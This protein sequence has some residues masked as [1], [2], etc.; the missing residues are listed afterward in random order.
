MS[1]SLDNRIVAPSINQVILTHKQKFP[2]E[3]ISK[4]TITFEREED[5]IVMCLSTFVH[6]Y[7][8]DY[9]LGSMHARVI[10]GNITRTE[11]NTPSLFENLGINIGNTIFKIIAY[12]V[13]GHRDIS[14]YDDS[15]FEDEPIRENNPEKDKLM[16]FYNYLDSYEEPIIMTGGERVNIDSDKN[17][18]LLQ[19]LH[20]LEQKLSTKPGEEPN[21]VSTTESVEDKV[22]IANKPEDEL[23]IV[24]TSESLEEISKPQEELNIEPTSESGVPKMDIYPSIELGVGEGINREDIFVKSIVFNDLKDVLYVP[25]IISDLNI[26]QIVSTFENNADFLDFHSALNTYVVTYLGYDVNKYEELENTTGDK[27]EVANKAIKASLKYIIN[28][29]KNTN[30]SMYFNFYGDI[31][32]L[33]L[34]SYEFI[35]NKIN[36]NNQNPFDILNSSEILYQFIIFYI[37]YISVENYDT[38]KDLINQM[39]GGDG[40]DDEGEEL[41]MDED[42]ASNLES[43]TVSGLLPEQKKVTEEIPEYVFITHNNLLTTITRGM[44]IKLGIWKR[45]F[46]PDIP[47]NEITPEDYKFGP[48][49]LNQISY[50]KLVELF[51]I[52]KKDAISSDISE[53]LNKG[54]PNNELLIL[55]ILILKRL[56]VEMSPKKTLTFGAKIDDD[57]KNYMDSFYVYN[58]NIKNE[59]IPDNI[60]I[61][62]IISDNPNF[63]S[64]PELEKET[65]ELFEM[66]EEGCEDYEQG[67]S[68]G[69]DMIMEGGNNTK[70]KNRDTSGDIEL[71]EITKQVEDVAPEVEDVAPEVE[72]VAP[73]VEDVAPEVEDV[74]P[75]VEDVAPEVE[76]IAP[77]VEKRELNPDIDIIEQPKPPRMPILFNKLKKMY[78]NNILTIKQLQDSEIEPITQDGETITNLYALLK[79]N[80]VLIHKK[81]TQVNI[82]APKYKFVINNAA[83]V[84]S[85][86]NG[87][88]MFIPRSYYLPIENTL[89]EIKERTFDENT[90][91]E[92]KLSTY[93]K[94]LQDI[95]SEKYNTLKAKYIEPIRQL[96]IRKRNKQIT[97]REYNE[98]LKLKYEQKV[99]ERTEIVQL[100]NKLFL[101]EVLQE[102]PEFYN[103]FNEKNTYTWF[104]DSQ[105]I[106][107]L[108]RSLQRGIFCPTSSMMDA[109][110]NCSLKYNTTEPKEV[111]TSYSEI[112]YNG[113]D[114]KYISFGG[115]V[116]N[117]NQKIDSNNEL[118]AKIYYTL[119][120]NVGANIDKDIMTINTVPI[121]VSESNDLKARVAYR[122]VVNKIKEIYDLTPK[123]ELVEGDE[124]TINLQ[125]LDYIKKMW[126]NMQYQ[127]DQSGFN[128]LLSA[129]SL[130]TMGDYLQEC[131]TCFKWGGYVSKSSSFPSDLK[132]AK[133]I[134]DKL[135]YRSVSEGGRIIPYDQLGNGLRL[136]IQGDRPSGFRSIYMLLNGNGAVNEQAITGY[137]FTSSTQNPSRSLLVARNKGKMNSNGLK[138]S[139]IYATREL[140]VPN[141]YDLLKELEFLNVADKSR[142]VYGEDVSQEITDSTIIGSEDVNDILLVNPRSKVK[143]LKNSAYEEL[144]DYNDTEFIPYIQEDEADGGT[145]ADGGTDAEQARK[146]RINKFNQKKGLTPT[147]KQAEKDRKNAEKQAEKDRKNAEKQAERDRKNAEKQAE[148]ERI[149]LF[150]NQ[151]KQATEIIKR[152][153][154]V[155]KGKTKIITTEQLDSLRERLDELLIDENVFNIIYEETKE[156]EIKNAEEE[157]KKQEKKAKAASKS[158]EKKERDRKLVEL[159]E[160]YMSTPDGQQKIKTIE[161]LENRI[162]EL[163]NSIELIKKQTKLKRGEKSPEIISK[164]EE[165]KNLDYEI[166]KINDEIESDISRMT[167]GKIQTRVIRKKFVHKITKRCYKM[168]NR[169]TKRNKNIKKPK[170]TRKNL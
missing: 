124:E 86:I 133:N 11:P 72:D 7:V 6:D 114:G 131:Q 52:P 13:G 151:I 23:N 128:M 55:E 56:L 4:N 77:E 132:I 127:Y 165:I 69:S 95:I 74:A 90:I 145:Q 41:E 47:I 106:F 96:N 79:L 153:I 14:M 76:D 62:D 104:R 119:D 116:L 112:V 108:Y 149:K 147:Q 99:F 164:E 88:K 98:L 70:D 157:K 10:K 84:G 28:D 53:N 46:F 58:Y 67:T 160:R 121:K 65:E 82:P 120:C 18:T 117:Y 80:Q 156:A 27:N 152:N 71:V 50:E 137:M 1:T 25:S 102:N 40:T 93:I 118:T 139:V 154:P 135:I 115:V 83:N 59:P 54:H 97:I 73:E 169:L 68:Y 36:N 8:H 101:A 92:E 144:I 16:S 91:N 150:K 142:K 126:K 34:D 29:F 103:N 48:K 111:G 43:S 22:D 136:G 130:K 51:P 166:V 100:E 138:G 61:D 2:E 89:A 94:G 33:L 12:P 163:Q 143:P 87:S 31:F 141:R 37:T 110:D 3:G 42:V 35:S 123:E 140:Q 44:F 134:K 129:T 85:N 17:S 9:N 45:I 63:A 162:G 81:G 105:P 57:L 167:G 107:G 161:E 146:E 5:M 168:K 155:T 60:I 24:P 64:N 30:T 32:S 148:T 109:M 49:E 159:R 75:E 21:V 125:G 38:F 20:G 66:C 78:Q 39:S 26:E 19:Q 15:K 170:R 158:A 122:G 113:P